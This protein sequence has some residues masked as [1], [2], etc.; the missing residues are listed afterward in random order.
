MLRLTRVEVSHFDILHIAGYR[1][2]LGHLEDTR[3]VNQN[4]SRSNST[5]HRSKIKLDSY[6][7]LA[8]TPSHSWLRILA[9]ATSTL[10]PLVSFTTL[11]RHDTL[12]LWYH[13]EHPKVSSLILCLKLGSFEFFLMAYLGVISSRLSNTTNYCFPSMWKI[14]SDWNPTSTSQI[15]Y[16]WLNNWRQILV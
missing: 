1:S 7:W 13:I 8:D 12:L 16:H 9:S 2:L 3:I 5:Y 14:I 11:L 10:G 4:I 6:V 15:S